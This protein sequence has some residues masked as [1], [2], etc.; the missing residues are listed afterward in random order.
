MVS[1]TKPFKHP[2]NEATPTKNLKPGSDGG[3]SLQGGGIINYP[4][5]AMFAGKYINPIL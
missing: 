5:S 1:P 2:V 4:S 3:G